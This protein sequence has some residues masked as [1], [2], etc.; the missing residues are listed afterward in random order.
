MKEF[1]NLHATGLNLSNDFEFHF[2]FKEKTLKKSNK[3]PIP[4]LFGENIAS[5]TGIL[6]VNGSGKT[7]SLE[8]ICRVLKNPEKIRNEYILIY[9]INNNFFFSTNIQQEIHLNFSASASS[10][11]HLKKLHV[12]F[13]SNV[14]DKNYIDF[15]N[16]V[17]D[18]S[19]NNKNNPRTLAT[20]RDTREIEFLNDI[21]FFS[22]SEFSK[23][24]LQPPPR[25]EIKIDRFIKRHDR[26]LEGD[27]SLSVLHYFSEV[28][29]ESR[30]RGK[31]HVI[32]QTIQLD[33]LKNLLINEMDNKKYLNLF[34]EFLL[35][36]GDKG[37]KALL[38][39]LRELSLV[40]NDVI[41]WN[42][43]FHMFETLTV[44]VKLES[45]LSEMCF[46]FDDSLRGSKFTFK[47]DYEMSENF[48]YRHIIGILQS[49]RYS[50]ISWSGLSSGQRAYINIFSSIWNGLRNHHLK[51]DDS[52]GTI[53]CIDEGDL[54]LHPQW[55]ADFVDRII[56]CLPKLSG[57]KI[58]I[59]FTT[60]SPILISDLPR[61][62]IIL[63]NNEQNRLSDL[64]DED[65][66]QP[67]AFA[68]NLYD[69]YQYSFGLKQS[70]SG[71]LSSRYLK[72]IY[73]ILD[74]AKLSSDDIRELN[75][76]LSVIDDDIIK[77]HI[78]RRVNSNDQY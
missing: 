31:L 23:I 55:Q 2:D 78:Q 30:G 24:N 33:F 6:G 7:N 27:N 4:D 77:Y 62:C 37:L 36:E 73:E 71:N 70:K 41:P 68:A 47:I 35:R 72:E 17:I 49:M 48:Y 18:I 65:N 5:I 12:I 66:N 29:R 63:L 74:K 67:K 8:F 64:H 54:Y 59:V 76:A 32:V 58:Q 60:H 69:I 46:D 61:Q 19:I 44:L 38:L 34:N 13:F 42:R 57:A 16:D 9:S 56:K 75:L 22:S 52:L 21:D 3:D 10:D 51:I 14:Y 1:K 40:D 26:L 53:I 20:Q 15:G 50:S 25:I 43:D 28:R 45:F 11:I 39:E